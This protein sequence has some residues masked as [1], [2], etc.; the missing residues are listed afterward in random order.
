[1]PP[2]A[3]P[4]PARVVVLDGEPADRV[5]VVLEAELEPDQQR[6][7][8]AAL[9]PQPERV[10][11]D[12][13]RCGEAERSPTP[14]VQLSGCGCHAPMIRPGGS[15][16]P[17][18]CERYQLKSRR[19]CS[20]PLGAGSRGTKFF[21]TRMLPRRSAKLPSGIGP[22]SCRPAGSRSSARRSRSMPLTSEAAE[23]ELGCAGRL[24]DADPEA[25]LADAVAADGSR[26][27][28]SRRPRRVEPS[29]ASI[30]MAIPSIADRRRVGVVAAPGCGSAGRGARCRCRAGAAA[31]RAGP[32]TSRLPPTW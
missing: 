6:P 18:G 7:R 27:A 32:I 16:S 11:L 21:A 23:D 10:E 13:A 24:E 30:E 5:R 19:F 20:T 15:S 22:R 2:V 1:M 8:L 31:R 17:A 9:Q 14:T 26:R 29:D 25:E 12:H 4:A 28:S 3:R